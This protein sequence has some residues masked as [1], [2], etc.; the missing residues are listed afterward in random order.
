MRFLFIFFLLV[1]LGSCNQNVP[2]NLIPKDKMEVLLWDY[3]KNDIYAFDHLQDS[4]HRD[5]ILSINM[6]KNLFSK[7]HV[8]EKEFNESYTYYSSNPKLLKEI[9]DSISNKER[10]KDIEKNKIKIDLLPDSSL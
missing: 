2:K 7:H 4:L 10:N 9:L 5:T 3:L 1:V 6:Q 8:T